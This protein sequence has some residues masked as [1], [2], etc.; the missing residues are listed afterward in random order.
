MILIP[1]IPFDIDEVCRLI[2]RRHERGRYF[3]I[4]VAAEG[5]IPK[6][7]TM[8]LPAGE[9]DEFGHP[10]LG[11]IG[12]RLEQ[13]IE[14]RT[15]FE[16][17]A[18]VLGHVQRGGTPTAFDRVLATRFGLAAIDAAHDGPV[19]DDDRAALDRDRARGAGRRG[20][21]AAHRS[22]RGV[23]AL[24]G[25]VRLGRPF[26]QSPFAPADYADHSV[27]NPGR[28]A[29]TATESS[30]AL[31]KLC[32]DTIRT[33][34]ID[35]VQKANSGHPGAPMG[36]AP[37]AYVLYTRVM[38]H[39]PADP[40][41][42]NRDRFILS[43][44]HASMLLYS[45]LYLTGYPMTL[46]DIEHFRQVGW[47][48]AGHPERKYSPGIEATTGPLGQGIAMSVGIALGERMLAARFNRDGHDDR[49]QPHV[50]DRVRRRHAGG[51]RLGGLLAGRPSRPGPPDR[52]LRR[53]QGPAR[54]PDL[55]V[56][57]RGRRPSA[58]RPTSGT[59]R[60]SARTCRWNGSRRR[61]GRRWRSRTARR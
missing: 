35:A 46:D 49:R 37:L 15:G 22:R 1:E 27:R 3:S 51:R 42:L 29:V 57:L 21:A 10:R 12:Y 40:D 17:R 52:V 25:P 5:A 26:R 41:W 28:R 18:T 58:T 50:H 43:A 14:Q 8:A 23:R 7:G 16:T 53:Q 13:E 11:G 31:D 36:L 19:G 60:T 48:T 47:P 54:G 30:T 32:V 61:P 6:E 38:R 9:L 55:A 24:R 45:M 39:N 56:V 2:R 59:S 33:L 20:R 4:V 34:S 44:G